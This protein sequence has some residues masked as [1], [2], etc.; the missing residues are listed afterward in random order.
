MSFIRAGEPL[1]RWYIVLHI[2]SPLQYTVS[3]IWFHSELNASRKN[4]HRASPE[5]HRTYSREHGNSHGKRTS[6]RSDGSGPHVGRNHQVR[7]G[8]SR[9]ADLRNQIA[10]IQMVPRHLPETPLWKRER[11]GHED[12]PRRAV[13]CRAPRPQAGPGVPEV[14]QAE[15][16]PA[17]S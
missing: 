8:P 6:G 17:V 4:Q 15:A 7:L 2:L 10:D 14:P 3:F 13:G 12:N 1:A 9:K 16:R 11:C 5:C